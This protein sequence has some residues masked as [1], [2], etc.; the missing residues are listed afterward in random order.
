MKTLSRLFLCAALLV[1][2]QIV[3]GYGA[4][5]L[6]LRKNLGIIKKNTA[7]ATMENVGLDNGFYSVYAEVDLTVSRQDTFGNQNI[8]ATVYTEGHF[9]E[10]ATAYAYVDGHDNQGNFHM[11]AASDSN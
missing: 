4:T 5:T 1:C 10:S 7:F 8:Q 6:T 11:D 9:S 2:A 3:Y